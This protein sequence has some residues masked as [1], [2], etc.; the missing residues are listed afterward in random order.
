MRASLFSI[1]LL[2]H[3]MR[4]LL[5]LYCAYKAPYEGFAISPLWLKLLSS[6]PPQSQ[7]LQRHVGCI[8]LIFKATRGE[9]ETY[10]HLGDE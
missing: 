6:I 10:H 7:V 4:A 8:P 3:L 9:V 5:F 2:R 1:V